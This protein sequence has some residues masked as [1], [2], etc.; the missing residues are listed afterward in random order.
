MSYFNA[1]QEAYMDYLARIPLKEKCWCGWYRHG[2][3]PH[4]PKDLTCA[5][6]CLTCHGAG[7]CWHESGYT[8]KRYGECPSCGGTGRNPATVF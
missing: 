5:D 3:C 7:K 4:C 8:E 6:K 2:G 1:E